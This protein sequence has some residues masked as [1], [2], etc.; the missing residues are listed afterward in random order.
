LGVA[1]FYKLLIFIIR[2]IWFEAFVPSTLLGGGVMPEHHPAEQE[3]K[4]MKKLGFEY[5]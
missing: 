1:Y 3:R 5:V 4:M 2:F